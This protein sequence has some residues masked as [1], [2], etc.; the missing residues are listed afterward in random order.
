MGLTEEELAERL[1]D[2]YEAFNRGDFDAALEFAHP[3]IVF[4]RPAGQSPLVGVEGIR[5]WM[6]P[7]AFESQRIEPLEIRVEGN[8]A[9]VRARTIAR[10]AGSGIELEADSLTVWTADDDGRAI[11]LETFLVEDE[12]AAIDALH[13]AELSGPTSGSPGR[14]SRTRRS[15]DR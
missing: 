5:E 13:R 8:R 12:E 11:R 7:D 2:A 14:R 10:G 9:L 4:V 1:R 3:K 6:E 15:A